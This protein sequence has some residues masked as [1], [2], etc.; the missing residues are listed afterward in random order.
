MLKY[1]YLKKRYVGY[2]GIQIYKK[3]VDC[4]QTFASNGRYAEFYNDLVTLIFGIE[5]TF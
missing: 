2:D 4:Q 1:Y 3:L 5:I